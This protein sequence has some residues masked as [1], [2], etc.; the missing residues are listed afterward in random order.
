MN[1]RRVAPLKTNL[2]SRKVNIVFVTY[3]PTYVVKYTPKNFSTFITPVRLQHPTYR[4]TSTCSAYLRALS[5]SFCLYH[6]LD[7]RNNAFAH[8]FGVGCEAFIQHFN[9]CFSALAYTDSHQL[10]QQ[11]YTHHH[12]VFKV[13]TIRYRVDEIISLPRKYDSAGSFGW[14][15]QTCVRWSYGYRDKI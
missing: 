9:H 10:Q 4:T 2:Y 11:Q 1:G 7:H 8:N 15:G 14:K 12:F 3:Y 6:R 5:W 13:R